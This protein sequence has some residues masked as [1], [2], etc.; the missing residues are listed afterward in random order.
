[1]NKRAP[2]RKYIRQLLSH[3]YEQVTRS[4]FR[5]SYP[6]GKVQHLQMLQVF[7]FVSGTPEGPN[8]SIRH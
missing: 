3:L 1:M 6:F 4:A 8:I 2:S 7:Y 5:K